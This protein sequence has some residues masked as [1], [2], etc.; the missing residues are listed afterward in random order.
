MS[1]K[2]DPR[3]TPARPD[4]AAKSL[5]GEVEAARFVEGVAYQC[6]AGVAAIRRA[7]AED[8]M[9]ETQLLFGETFTVYDE[10]D[11]WG[12]GQAAFDGY[13]GYVAMEALAAPP[14]APTHRISALRTYVF[15]EAN[16]KSAP[17]FLL[18]LNARV[19]EEGRWGRFVKIARSGWVFEGHLRPLRETAADF[20]TEAERF[21]G[22]PYFWGGRESLGLDCSGLVQTAL[23]AA[24]IPCPRDADQQEAALGEPMPVELAGLR[25]G[26]LIFWPGHCGIMLDGARL[27][28][29]NAHHMAVAIEPITEAAQRI[30]AIA[31]P[32]R[33][34]R[35]L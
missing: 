35:R 9:Q 32:I 16:L 11:G 20:V 15:S 31:G 18:S 23:T 26:D 24:G 17:H 7:P 5:E 34:V 14:L 21:L 27:L 1:A 28:H 8:A 22:A 4:V 2:R 25:R 6:S 29:A 10:R 33:S 3:L 19:T 13:V 30:A 12:W